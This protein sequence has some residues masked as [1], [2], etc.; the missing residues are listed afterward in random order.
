[1][2]LIEH[3]RTSP[4]VHTLERLA[5]ALDVP[6]TAFFEPEKDLKQVVFT[7]HDARPEATFEMA[8]VGSLAKNLDASSL[9]L[10]VTTLAPGAQSGEAGMKHNGYEF[11]YCLSGSMQYWIADR[12]YVLEPGDSLVFQARLLHRWQNPTGET[13][14]ILLVLFDTTS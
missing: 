7:R 9:Q 12:E 11:A 13:A 10:F 4:S 2:S 14:E 3:N 1:L 6:I 8:S 5:R